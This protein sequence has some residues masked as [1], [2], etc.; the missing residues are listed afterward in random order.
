MSMNKIIVFII[1]VIVIIAIWFWVQAG[2]AADKI[3][4]SGADHFV[5]QTVEGVTGN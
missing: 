3:L 5:E 4:E 1:A 2:R